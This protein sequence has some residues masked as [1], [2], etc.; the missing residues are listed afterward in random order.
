MMSRRSADATD[1]SPPLRVMTSHFSGVVTIICVSSSSFL[2]SCVSPVS[3]RTEMPSGARRREKAPVT[4]AASAFIGATY[5][6]LKS[7]ASRARGSIA[8]SSSTRLAIS[9]S[10][11]IIAMFVFPAPVGA[12]TS[13]FSLLRYAAS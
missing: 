1:T 6:I 9:C 5:T 2:L 4:S 12:H 10:T 11:V 3:S 13:R 8:P 7:S